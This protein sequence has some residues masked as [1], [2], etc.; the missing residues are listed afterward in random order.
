M[1]KEIKNFIKYGW[2]G[3]LASPFQYFHLSNIIKRSNGFASFW[4]KVYAAMAISFFI[5]F[6]YTFLTT[7]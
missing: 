2:E 3:Y 5:Y 4:W 1:R 6:A 7:K